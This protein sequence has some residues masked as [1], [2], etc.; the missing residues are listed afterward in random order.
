MVLVIVE[1]KSKV[2][3]ISLAS[4]PATALLLVVVF[5]TLMAFS[6]DIVFSIHRQSIL[7]QPSYSFKENDGEVYFLNQRLYRFDFRENETSNYSYVPFYINGESIDYDEAFC[8]DDYLAVCSRKID[9][10]KSTQESRVILFDYLFNLKG[11]ILLSDVAVKGVESIGE[12]LLISVYEHNMQLNKLIVYD[13][14]SFELIEEINHISKDSKFNYEGFTIYLGSNY[15]LTRE[16]KDSKVSFFKEI[17]ANQSEC[18]RYSGFY[19]TINDNRL[20]VT[21]N[22]ET[23]NYSERKFSTFYKKAYLLDNVALF[24]AFEEIPNK[25]CGAKDSYTCICRYGKSYLFSY[26]FLVDELNLLGEFSEGTFLID[27]DLEGAK[28]YYDG[29]LYIN[30]VLHRECMKIEPGEPE[31]VR[32]N[33]HFLKNEGKIDYYLCYLDGEFYGI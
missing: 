10:Q 17:D 22:G 30:G 9:Y 3:L 25:E 14:N 4:I 31:K 29:G 1:K 5:A 23:T 13:I 6:F 21:H 32:G 26:D 11:E 12:K 19:A 16:T 20:I 2:I 24:A 7:Q 28:Y 27:Y 18:L 33:D 15:S 8:T